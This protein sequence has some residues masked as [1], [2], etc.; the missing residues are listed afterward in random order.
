VLTSSLFAVI[1]SLSQSSSAL[2]STFERL[3][4]VDEG[5]RS[6]KFLPRNELLHEFNLLHSSRSIVSR[7]I[8]STPSP[9][10]EVTTA[11]ASTEAPLKKCTE[12]GDGA[13]SSKLALVIEEEEFP[14]RPGKAHIEAS[15]DVVAKTPA[16]EDE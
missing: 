6:I 13:G 10:V 4:A 14:Q 15:K 12:P 7:S 1:P 2:K 5:E 16:E 9:Q 11:L 8:P 3:K